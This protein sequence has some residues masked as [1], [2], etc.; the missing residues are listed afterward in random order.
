MENCLVIGDSVVCFE[1]F[2]R[3]NHDNMCWRVA[4]PSYK[5][6]ATLR[7]KTLG[8]LHKAGINPSRIDVFVAN[9]EQRKE[10][11][12][13]IPSGWFDKIIVGV[14]GMM[15]IRNFIQDYYQEGQ[16]IVC[17]DDDLKEIWKI[18]RDLKKQEIE[19]IP[20]L[21]DYAFSVCKQVG[22]DYWGIYAAGNTF[23]M[24]RQISLGLR[25]LIGSMWGMVVSH[26]RRTYVTIDDKEDFERSVRAYLKR[27]T[28]V[29]L[30][31]VSVTSNYYGEK[32]G[33]QEERTEQRVIES[34]KRLM[35]MFPYCVVRNTARK[36]HF[37]VKLVER[38]ENWKTLSN[39]KLKFL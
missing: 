4:I 15:N 30:D 37:E 12:D 2:A 27:G 23:Y 19:S 29:R 36:R 24:K 38:R 28:V 21:F 13:T 35:A 6:A 31:F 22:S 25:Y 18:G 5:R 26:D 11:E 17:L 32:G 14:V 7:D 20:S 16:M 34:G 8:F 10:Y 3:S 39:R 1:D 9:E 33:M